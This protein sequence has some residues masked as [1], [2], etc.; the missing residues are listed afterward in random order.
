MDGVTLYGGFVGSETSLEGRDVEFH[1]TV[2]SGDIGGVGNASDN[3][4]T[5]VYCGSQIEAGIDGVT[6]T[7]GNADEPSLSRGP[8]QTGGGIF[9]RGGLVVANTTVTENQGRWGGGV[10]NLLGTLGVVNSTLSANSA[11]GSGGGAV[12]NWEGSVNAVN[13]TFQGNS[14]VDGGAIGNFGDFTLINSIL[15]G[16]TAQAGGGGITTRSTLYVANSA[17]A[18]NHA[19]SGGGIFGDGSPDMTV[20]NTVIAANEAATEADIVLGA[21]TID[22]QHCYIGVGPA[23]PNPLGGQNGNVVGSVKQPLDPPFVNDP[24][25]GGDGWGDDPATLTADES[26][27]DDYG[28]LHLE[29]DATAINSGDAAL[30]PADTFDLDGDGDTAEAIPFDLAGAPRV[31]NN[32][33]DMGAYE[34]PLS[35]PIPDSV[36]F[37]DCDA[38]TGGNGADWSSAFRDLQAALDLATAMNADGDAENDVDQIWIAEGTYR[39]SARL[40]PDEARSI[41]FSMVDGVTLYGG[42]AGTETALEERS[43]AAGHETILSGDVGVA[44]AMSDNAYTVVYCESQIEAGLDGVTVTGGNADGVSPALSGEV[45]G[46][47][48]FNRGVLAV[49]AAAIIGNSAHYGAGIHNSLG[50]LRVQD[51]LIASNSASGGDGGGILNWQ[52]SVQV[53]NSALNGNSAGDGGAIGNRGDFRMV[54]STLV[55]NSAEGNGGGIISTDFLSVTTSTIAGNTAASGGGVYGDDNLL[56]MTY[57]TIIAGNQ[58]TNGVDLLVSGGSVDVRYCLIG[59]GSGLPA[60]SDG[61]NGNVVGTMNSPIDPRLVRNP[62]DGGDGW[63]DNP[64]TPTLDESANDDFGDLQLQLNSPA[65]NA[66]SNMMLSEDAFDMDGDGDTLEAIPFDLAGEA[67]VRHTIVDM[68][69]YETSSAPPVPDSVLFVDCDAPAGGN[70][71]DWPSAFRDLQAALDLATAMNAD[72]D[73]ENDVDQIWIAEGTYRPSARRDSGDPRSASFSLV[74]GVALFGGFVG[75]EMALQERNWKTHETVLSGDIGSPEDWSDN[76]YTVVYCANEV[77]ATMDA[78]TITGGAATG[79]Y[80]SGGGVFNEGRLAINNAHFVQNSAYQGNAIFNLRGTMDLCN[81]TV[82][83]RPSGYSSSEEIVNEWGTL[84]VVNTSIVSLSNATYVAGVINLYGQLCVA[85]ST[86]WVD[87]SSG[88]GIRSFSPGTLKLT[89]SI[90]FAHADSAVIGDAALEGGNLI[91]IDP[92][93]VRNPRTDGPDDYGDLRLTSESPAIDIG[94][95]D[96]LPADGWDLDADGET[97]E[98]LPID[99]AGDTRA[100]GESLD[101]GAYEY[102][103]PLDPGRETP[104]TRV[105]TPFDIFSLY[106]GYTSLREAAY[107]VGVGAVDTPIT[108]ADSIAGFTL[109][110]DGSSILIG[111][112]LTIDASAMPGG[113]TIDADGNSRVFTVTTKPSQP[114]NLIALNIRGGTASDGGG[115]YTVGGT[116]HVRDCYLVDNRARE[117]GGAVYNTG[118]L[119]VTNST[120]LANESYV[121]GG[122]FYNRGTLYITNSTIA[123][124]QTESL[125]SSG[126]GVHNTGELVVTNTVFVGNSASGEQSRGGAVYSAGN[127]FQSINSTYCGNK[128]VDGGGI[129]C[130]GDSTDLTLINSILWGNQGG[131]LFGR[132]SA[133]SASN[134]IAI[135]PAFVRNPGTNGKDDYGD[136]RPT[137]QSAAVDAGDYFLLPPDVWDADRD[138]DTTEVL[139]VDLHGDA[140]KH[141]ESVDI[142]AYEF[143]EAS[144][145]GRETPS[146]VV[147]VPTDTSDPYDGDISLR[148]AVYYAQDG[149]VGTTITFAPELSGATVFLNGYA[150][151][152]VSGVTIDASALPEGFVVDGGG[153]SAVFVATA[154]E[155]QPVDL[156]GLIVRNGKG[157]HGGG[158]YIWYGTVTANDVLFEKNVADGGGAVYNDRG[159]FAGAN[160]LFTAN[161]A[162]HGGGA[163]FNSY[164]TLTLTNSEF[165]ANSAGTL[166]GGIYTRGDLAISHSTFSGNTAERGGGAYCTYSAGV[167]NNVVLAAN[168]ASLGAAPDLYQRSCDLTGSHNLIGEGDENAPFTHGENGNLVGTAE[169]PIDPKFVRNPSDGGDGWGDDLETPDIDESANDDYGDLRLRPDSPAVDAGDAALLPED[170]FDLDGDG[171]VTEPIPVDLA[172]GARVEGDAVDMGAYEYVAAP[173]VPGDLDN[174]GFVGSSDLDIVRANWGWTVTPGSLFD[175]DATGDGKVDSDDLNIVRA[176]WG[177]AAPAGVVAVSETVEKSTNESKDESEKECESQCEIDFGPAPAPRRHEALLGREQ[178]RALANAAWARSVQAEKERS[179]SREARAVDAVLLAWDAVARERR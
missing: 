162:V 126:G 113:V 29:F 82:A 119:S 35:L 100:Y 51:S 17:I 124:N 121:D 32:A 34:R 147:T 24:S 44:N 88:T 169:A 170:A 3:A 70:G 87:G 52:G 98:P 174:D 19:S 175:G 30:L 97:T 144:P 64:A 116:L 168:T 33:L 68:G 104:S 41:T 163:I 166:G 22:V 12:F 7:G 129:C 160:T 40:L 135:D 31:Q 80:T 90:V 137:A 71:A 13:S 115:I 56:M 164:G 45:A 161:S 176:N 122:A 77:D 4:Y 76:T 151:Q 152:L 60:L 86:V 92:K 120:V 85:N 38:P 55:G 143:Q 54:N 50:S 117:K 133:E 43:L 58:A 142:G 2:L 66:G 16:N 153:Q 177:Q 47:G 172:G 165:S 178:L 57:N 141:G 6:V 72:G 139:P 155:S 89:N 114:V 73:A 53:V 149:S 8:G 130:A 167:F 109:K 123:G 156:S 95:A 27:N 75:S 132:L 62:S 15:V 118:T 48:V 11:S 103:A 173:P 61:Q 84:N 158:L 79:S 106:D 42:F 14:A 128:A 91:G 145:A 9:N 127:G 159:T 74:D 102:Q 28:D 108:F 112:S 99:L 81:S 134:L 10:F 111:A 46:G 25:D 146:T 63:G 20:Y 36:V 150:I 140:R 5:V 110:L 171:N 93:F 131:E 83:N 39:P 105:T 49:K 148:E 18:G 125:T 96:L 69:A 59:D 1:E 136:L 101:A 21:G 65:V 37:V 107:Y 138:D 157:Y 154:P 94:N 67:R 78:I 23:V 179:G 26:V